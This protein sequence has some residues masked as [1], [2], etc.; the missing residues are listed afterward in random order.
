MPPVFAQMRGDAVRARRLANP[1]GL[2]RT[3]FA[4]SAPAIT[5]LADR[6][7][8]VN[9]DSEFEHKT[10]IIFASKAFVCQMRRQ[11]A[12]SITF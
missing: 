2:N 10:K 7:D 6:G 8:V 12:N 9:V 3:G 11:F 5:R 4:E 1:R